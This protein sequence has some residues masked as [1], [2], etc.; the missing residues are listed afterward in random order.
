MIRR[1]SWARTRSSSIC[2]RLLERF[3]DRL[4]GDLVEHQPVD[5]HLRLQHL[6]E[7]PTD[8]LALAVFV[9]RQIEVLGVLQQALELADLLGLVAGNRCRPARNPCRRSRP[10]RPTLPPL[11][12]AGIS[13]APCGKSRMWP[14]LASIV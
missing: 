10:G 5:R 14:M 2:A 9:R 6:A 7:V 11:Y 8:G 3:A 4:F 13:L 1:A 12:S